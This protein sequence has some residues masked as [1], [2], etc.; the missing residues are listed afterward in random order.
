[1]QSTAKGKQTMYS[2]EIYIMRAHG[3]LPTIPCLH[4][5][6]VHL[7][8][9]WGLSRLPRRGWYLQVEAETNIQTR[10][11]GA[12]ICYTNPM[13]SLVQP[14]FNS[15]RVIYILMC[16]GVIEWPLTMSFI[17]LW[18]LN[19]VTTIILYVGPDHM[20]SVFVSIKSTSNVCCIWLFTNIKVLFS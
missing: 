16:Q 11:I 15:G 10:T 7:H 12:C 5:T 19:G 6:W 3:K 20:L 18:Q 2:M 9:Q 17:Q 13:W 1:M 4:Q 14:L 8:T